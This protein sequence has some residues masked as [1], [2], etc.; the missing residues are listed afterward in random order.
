MEGTKGWSSHHGWQDRFPLGQSLQADPCLHLCTPAGTSAWEPS[1]RPGSH[2]LPWAAV[3]H[4]KETDSLCFCSDDK[5][6]YFITQSCNFPSNATTRTTRLL[7]HRL[8]WPHA[9]LFKIHET[10]YVNEESKQGVVAVAGVC[11][12]TSFINRNS[13]AG[14]ADT[15]SRTIRLPAHFQ[16]GFPKLFSTEITTATPSS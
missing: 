13:G 12:I 8:F 14:K 5:K 10:I 3:R 15:L 16:P 9:G 4:K 2:L 11:A 7:F 1:A 6:D